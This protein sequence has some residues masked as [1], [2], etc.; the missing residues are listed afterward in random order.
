MNSPGYDPIKKIWCDPL[1]PPVYNTDAGLGYLILNSLKST[2]DRVIEISA[3][4]GTE[5]TCI[6]MFK[7]SVK[8]SRFLSSLGLEQHDV[9]GIIGRNS[10]NLT[11]LVIACL[12]LG[13]PINALAPNADEIKILTMYSNTKPK[14][15]FCDPDLIDKLKRLKEEITLEDSKVITLL[16][17]LEGFQ[18]IDEIIKRGDNNVN[19]FE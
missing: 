12:T 17:E 13:L 18:F 9:I 7:K 2:P 11:P 3:D 5:T 8:I 4:D 14:L 16:D 1:K 15:I 19:D 10:K 6:E